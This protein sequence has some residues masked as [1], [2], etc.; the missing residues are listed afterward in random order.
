M[1]GPGLASATPDGG[2]VEDGVSSSGLAESTCGST[3][4]EAVSL[5]IGQRIRVNTVL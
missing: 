1:S 3:A 2:P 4:A 5:K